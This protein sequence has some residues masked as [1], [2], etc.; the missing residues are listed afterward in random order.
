MVDM[1]R[2]YGYIGRRR[3]WADNREFLHEPRALL[4]PGALNKR[5]MIKHEVEFNLSSELTSP[6]FITYKLMISLF[7]CSPP[8]A[9]DVLI[10]A[11]FCSSIGPEWF[12]PKISY[13]QKLLHEFAGFTLHLKMSLGDLDLLC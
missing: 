9:I 2:E 4:I 11:G 10:L 8:P 5:S 1:C 3:L 12:I 7:S 13:H 6:H